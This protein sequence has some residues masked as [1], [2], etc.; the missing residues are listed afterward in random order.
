MKA[1]LACLAIAASAAL[2]QSPDEQMTFEV[3]SV[4][5][6]APMT[7]G[8]FSFGAKGGPG[9]SDP[10]QITYSSLSLK[11]LLVMSF[12]VKPYQVSG[13]DWLDSERFD[14]VAKVP[15][16]ATKEQARFM[17]QNLLKERFHLTFHHETKDLPMYSLTVGKSGPKFK[18]S[19]EDPPP[20]ATAA[21]GPSP[22]DDAPRVFTNSGRITMGPDGM[23]QLPAGMA[24]KTGCM[25]MMMMNNGGPRSHM[26]CTKQSMELFV[27]QLANQLDKPVTDLTNLK[28]K[29]DF[30]LDFAP[31]PNAMGGKLPMMAMGGGSGTMIREERVGPGP[32]HGG[33]GG[34]RPEQVAAPPLPAAL[35]E[36]LG[37]KL[38]QKKGPVD[39]IVV[40]KMEKLPTEN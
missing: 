9:T 10:G 32:G 23:P 27:A 33:D 26:V 30:T 13:P 7:A 25:S 3:A 38:D 16:G 20:A 11:N 21:G 34:D 37:L 17:L 8:R 4:K 29:Y 6:S 1:L 5:P 31:D 22:T 35:Q 40:D 14:I 19:P 12:G 2:A 18:E 28:A 39:M 36:Q 24:P 15:A